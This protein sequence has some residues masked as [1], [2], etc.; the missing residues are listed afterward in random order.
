MQKEPHEIKDFPTS[1]PMH[2]RYVD[3]K[4][5]RQKC[6]I[7]L[8]E[9]VFWQMPL[10]HKYKRKHCMYICTNV[11]QFVSKR[12]WKHFIQN[13]KDKVYLNITKKSNKSVINRTM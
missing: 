13:I 11:V 4:T 9:N 7:Q 2:T 1:H 3:I 12:Y 8:K 5:F 10:F 6:I